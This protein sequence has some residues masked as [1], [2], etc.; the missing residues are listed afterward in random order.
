MTGEQNGKMDEYLYSR[1]IIIL[2]KYLLTY[3][4]YLHIV[5]G[6]GV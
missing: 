2:V 3:I 5:F 1:I 6:H 4:A